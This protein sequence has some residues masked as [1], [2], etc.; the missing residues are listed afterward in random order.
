MGDLPAKANMV[1]TIITNP[2]PGD[3]LAPNETFELRANIQN[4]VAGTFTN[5][6]K[7]YYAAPQTLQGGKVVGH[8]HFTVQDMG[9]SIAPNQALPA[10]TFAFF[11][12]VDDNGDGN[13]NLVAQ[14]PNGLPKGFYRVCTMSSSSNHQAVVMPV[15]Q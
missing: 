15:A 6:D 7:T 14:V 10:A 12:G 4:L 2:K 1:S 11:K 5:P 9:N 3:D 13:G 8:M